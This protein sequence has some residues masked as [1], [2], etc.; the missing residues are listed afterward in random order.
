MISKTKRDLGPCHDLAMMNRL[1]ETVH[2]T[3]ELHQDTSDNTYQ[4]SARP[5][6]QLR[7]HTSSALTG[8]PTGVDR[9]RVRPSSFASPF[10]LD[11]PPTVFMCLPT[12]PPPRFCPSAYLL[13]PS[14]FRNPRVEISF[15]LVQ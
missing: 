8:R 11:V 9:F 14:S 1:W 10:S 2:L 13:I 12:P 6:H 4:A 3:S 15:P 7:Q 5:V